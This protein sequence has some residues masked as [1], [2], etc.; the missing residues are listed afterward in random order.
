MDN[1]KLAFYLTRYDTWEFIRQF[2]N[3][4]TDGVR[5]AVK[6]ILKTTVEYIDRPT[7]PSGRYAN[8]IMIYESSF[9]GDPWHLDYASRNAYGATGTPN[10]S[11]HSYE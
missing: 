6:D 2:N 7:T 4:D 10:L 3:E 11:G 9:P 5:A 8:Q 1:V